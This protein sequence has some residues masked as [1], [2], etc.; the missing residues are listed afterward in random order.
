M[1][2]RDAVKAWSSSTAI[3]VL[4]IW[5]APRSRTARSARLIGERWREWESADQLLAR[6][7]AASPGPGTV[8]FVGGTVLFLVATWAAWRARLS[9]AGPFALLG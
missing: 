8:A 7:R 6:S 2:D 1:V 5:S 9:A 3:L 4:A